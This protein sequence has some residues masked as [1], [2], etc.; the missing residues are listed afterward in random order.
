METVHA[1][2]KETWGFPS[3]FLLSGLQMCPDQVA[4]HCIINRK[5]QGIQ[6]L[7]IELNLSKKHCNTWKNL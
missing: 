2:K 4:Q 6:M 1:Y 3:C 7:E 5:S